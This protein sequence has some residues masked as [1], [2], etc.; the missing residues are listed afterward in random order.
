MERGQVILADLLELVLIIYF[1]YCILQGNLTK[2]WW[3]HIVSLIFLGGSVFVLS[4]ISNE[5]VMAITIFVLDFFIVLWSFNDGI[6]KKIQ[7]FI[8]PSILNCMVQEFFAS[9]IYLFTNIKMESFWYN[10]TINILL[11]VLNFCVLV[12]ASIGIKSLRKKYRVWDKRIPWLYILVFCVAV[13][14]CNLIIFQVEKGIIDRA[15]E[16]KNKITLLGIVLVV[17]LFVI[18]AVVLAII[19]SARNHYVKESELK[20]RYLLMQERYYRKVYEDERKIKGLRHDIRAHFGCVKILVND[21]KY[22]ELKEYINQL[23]VVVK[24]VTE[25]KI[26]CGNHI[27]N[28]VLNEMDTIARDYNTNIVSKG[29]IPKTIKITFMDLCTLFY[30]IVSNAEEACRDYHGRL[31]KEIVVKITKYKKNLNIKVTNPI[32]QSV[33]L[34]IIGKSTQKK[35]KEFHGFGIRNVLDVVEKYNGKI[36]FNNHEGKFIVELLF[37]DIF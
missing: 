19:D 25:G 15:D 10:N 2:K 30:N 12:V 26:N 21:G 7:L 33:D 36:E 18:G 1:A 6:F 14:C 34:N 13:L 20:D 35:D 32:M 23:D 37:V 31:E 9:L 28:A 16:I 4:H 29:V 17:I 11:K 24:E 3:K 22:N 5:V 27:V 8:V